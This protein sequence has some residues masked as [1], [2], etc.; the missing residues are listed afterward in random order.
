LSIPA[1]VHLLYANVYVLPADTRPIFPPSK[2]FEQRSPFV[3][4][5]EYLSLW[6]S[7]FW[8]TTTPSTPALRLAYSNLG[9]TVPD[10]NGS[11]SR[12]MSRIFF[13]LQSL[14]IIHDQS[15]LR[16]ILPMFFA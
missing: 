4:T 10:S 13:L 11:D 1:P 5:Q 12:A 6:R 7:Q 9:I 3:S 15:S 14:L 16:H 2:H 8:R